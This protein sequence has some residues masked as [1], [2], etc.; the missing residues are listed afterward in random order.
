MSS[1]YRDAGV[2]FKF[3]KLQARRH[4]RR[5]IRKSLFKSAVIGNL[6]KCSDKNPYF[7]VSCKRRSADF[8]LFE[9]E[10]KSGTSA[11]QIKENSPEPPLKTMYQNPSFLAQ[12]RPP[13]GG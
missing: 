10:Q 4:F 6:R 1:G 2:I 13:E 8:P 7:S 9:I 11:Y 12:K 5:Q 3:L